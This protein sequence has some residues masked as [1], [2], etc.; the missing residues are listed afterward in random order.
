VQILRIAEALREDDSQDYADPEA[1]AMLPHA[2]AVFISD[3]LGDLDA[4]KAA[5]LKAADRGIRGLLVQVLDPA[6]EG[7]P[8]H[9]RT[10]FDSMGETITHE[11]L[12][13]GE[14]KAD[15]LNRLAA[16]KAELQHLCDTA[17]WQYLC[18]H[19]STPAQSALLW[20]HRA[21]EGT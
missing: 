11:T 2:R 13:A 15:Y 16:R 7:F 12:N 19:T 10:I 1:R 20:M 4:I 5:L 18:H 17:N 9:G 21:L 6:E 14:L 8:F 3:F